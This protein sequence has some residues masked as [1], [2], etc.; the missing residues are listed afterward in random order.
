[1]ARLITLILIIIAAVSSLTMYKW[2]DFGY[3][4][5][6]I[7]DYAF[8][9][10]LLTAGGIL[11]LSIFALLLIFKLITSLYKLITYFGT[12]RKTRLLEQARSALSNGLID[13]AE[14]RFAE[15]EKLLL[16]HA[17]HSD[18][19]L[20]TY[21]SAA[22]AAQQ[23]GEH[24]RRDDY[25]RKAHEATP[26]AEIAIGLTKAELQLAHDQ[27]E[28]A[29]ANLTHLYQLSPKH[30]YVLKLLLKTYRQLSDW[31][32]IQ[33]LL[34]DAKHQKLLSQEKLQNL[35]LET[36]HGLL[37]DQS[38]CK[39]VETLTTIWNELP[40][41][42]KSNSGLVEYY[43]LLLLDLNAVKQAEQV[44]RNCLKT[45]WSESTIILYAEIDVIIDNQQLEQIESW[46]Q[47]H[48]HNAHLLLALGKRCLSKKLWGKARSHLEASLAINAMPET[49]LKLAQLLEQ[50]MDEAKQAQVYYQQGL[51]CLVGS[52]HHD[53]ETE[54]VQHNNEK[55]VLQIVQ[56]E[57]T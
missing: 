44:L 57:T 19:L 53:I 37:S 30:A 23:Q 25:L 27:Y 15:A 17:K 47:E 36:W 11:L 5:A 29:L 1:M 6:G 54:A 9:T 33:A 50:H 18:N 28:Q 40:G 2:H 46:L 12:N 10:T 31:K 41:D 26:T 7:N 45:N 52:K 51:E 35:E 43:A 16:K 56:S 21:L 39:D 13:L 24:E 4:T 32:N 49:Y 55:P 48:Q 14:G 20:L 22:R 38:H 34:V 3:L 8:E 42:L